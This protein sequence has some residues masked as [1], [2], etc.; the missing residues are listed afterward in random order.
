[1]S[2]R[3]LN[4]ITAAGA[5]PT[6]ATDG[7]A[8][9]GDQP[10]YVGYWLRAWDAAQISV[11]GSGTGALTFQGQIYLYTAL[12]GWAP[13]GIAVTS[14]NRGLLNDGNTITGTT[15]LAHT[16]PVQGLSAYQ[17]IALVPTIVTAGAGNQTVSAYLVPRFV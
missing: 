15:T 6:L 8:L 13:A 4:G 2:L 1:M 9:N 10:G 16:Q 17:R 12:N 7:F 5:A 3:L 11:N 14:S